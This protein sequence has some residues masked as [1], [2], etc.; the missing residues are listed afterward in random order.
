VKVESIE[1]VDNVLLRKS[2]EMKVKVMIGVI[3]IRLV[4]GEY[5]EGMVMRCHGQGIVVGFIGGMLEGTIGVKSMHR[6]TVYHEEKN[7][8]IYAVESLGNEGYEWK[9]G[10]KVRVKVH[11]TH[12][13]EVYEGPESGRP[14]M[15]DLI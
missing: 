10:A 13:N 6:D 5:F 8:W 11:A 15:A 4:V 2:G 1:I 14:G 7:Q 12:W 9:I 3:V